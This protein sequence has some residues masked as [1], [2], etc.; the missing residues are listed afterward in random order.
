M[1][2]RLLHADLSAARDAYAPTVVRAFAQLKEI[3]DESDLAAAMLPLDG[4]SGK[5]VPICRLHE[6]D[7]ELMA[8]LSSWRVRNMAVYPTQFT[9]T[10]AG[11]ARWLRHLVLAVPDRIT[12]LVIEANGRPVGHVGLANAL[13]GTR[14]VRLDNLM[15]G[16]D[17]ASP[18]IMSAAVRS[19]IAWANTTI[20]PD[21]IWLKVFRENQVAIRF[22][23]RLGFRPDGLIPL[24]AVV[25]GDRLEYAPMSAE[26]DGPP[27]R[28]QLRMVLPPGT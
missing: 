4:H 27:D 19:L 18:G 13:A 5:L 17:E 1:R 28:Y 3:V 14:A 20:A 8:L 6:S 16:T 24:R 25:S 7:A 15:R 22:L 9:V 26:D 23:Q 10:T 21:V 2:S 11:T 12:F